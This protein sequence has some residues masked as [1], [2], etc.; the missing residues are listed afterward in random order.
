MRLANLW[1]HRGWGAGCKGT[2]V[3]E[4]WSTVFEDGEACVRVGCI[5]YVFSRGVRIVLGCFGGPAPD[6]GH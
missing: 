5:F 3:D 1:I 4:G 2:N 6:F